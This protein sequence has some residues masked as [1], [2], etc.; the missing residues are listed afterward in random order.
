MC[1]ALC[2]L[3]KALSRPVVWVLS[4]KE[5][6]AQALHS[7]ESIGLKPA[8]LLPCSYTVASKKVKADP[9]HLLLRTEAL[10]ALWQ[11]KAPLILTYP[12]ALLEKA[13]NR[14]IFQA[15]TLHVQTGADLDYT[16]F[17][18]QLEDLGFQREDFVYEPG[19]YA[20]RGGIMD[21][22]S[23]ADT[24]PFRIEWGVRAPLSIR[25]FDPETQRSLR[26]EAG[27]QIVASLGP[28]VQTDT[29]LWDFLPGQT[30]FFLDRQRTLDEGFIYFYESLYPLLDDTEQTRFVSADIAVR[31]YA[32]FDKIYCKEDKIPPQA[33]VFSFNT[34]LQY[35]FN[36]DFKGLVADMQTYAAKGYQIFMASDQ[37]LQ[38]QRVAAIVADI[39]N[40]LLVTPYLAQLTEG[41]VDN[42]LKMVCYAERDIFQRQAAHPVKR[43]FS[44]NQALTLK[45]LSALQPGDFVT[46][47][48]YGVGRFSGLEKIKRADTVQEVIRLIYKNNDVLYVSIHA[49]YKLSKYASA[50]A[51]PPAL[52][53]LGGG[54]WKKLKEKTK[55][56]IKTLAFD[57]ISA[58]A[59]R[60]LEKGYAFSEDNYLQMA[61]EA[62]FIYE[63]TPDQAAAIAAV[64][65]DMES[66]APM[67]RLICGD[68][69][70]GK[71]EI[72][73]RAAF[74]ACMDGKQVAVLAPT[75]VLVF[76]HY[77]TF[78]K[79][80]EE[81]PL[82]I[83]YINRFKT[84]KQKKD[85]IQ[86]LSEG[87]I[88]II[89]GTH[90]LLSKKIRFKDLGLLIVDEEQKF[91][92]EAKE[93]LKTLK[94]NVDCLMLTATPI[95]RTLQF[96]L[97][98]ARD[99]SIIHT[100]PPNRQ[101]VA[102][103]VEDF[104][105]TLIQE[106][107]LREIQRGGQVFFI[108][109]QISDI[110]KQVAMIQ[111]LCPQALVTYAHRRMPAKQLET[112]LLDF[113]A[114]KY[115]VFVSTNI[116]ESGVDIPNT[117]T[118]IIN[119]AQDFGLSDL[120][121]LRGRVG[122]SEKKAYCYLLTPAFHKLSDVS[123]KKLEIIQIFS[124]L[125]AGFKVAMKDLDLR[126]AG[127]ILGGEQSGFMQ[128]VGIDTYQK[129]LLEAV[130]ELKRT[131]FKE[132]FKQ[133]ETL[134]V[135]D[136]Q[137]E[138]DL[139]IFIP[140]DYIE[141]SAERLYF[142]DAV[143]RLKSEAEEAAIRTELTDRFGAIPPEAA[144][145]LEVVALRRLGQRLG[146]EKIVLK[147]G[148]CQLLFVRD[149]GSAFYESPVF[150][151]ILDYVAQATRH[152]PKIQQIKDS[153]SIIFLEVPAVSAAIAVLAGV[154]RPQLRV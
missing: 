153:F 49:L 25:V 36:R 129:L 89:I 146:V 128:E 95:P 88:D 17:I 80:M 106:L 147:N 16:A 61:L 84:L 152:K 69:G 101:P 43:A 70:F 144:V 6:A 26:T 5:T 28:E 110:E 135:S 41:F 75:T 48:D 120:H 93:Y 142:Y 65:R 99:L 54:A 29:A 148:C 143:S 2:A 113:I 21:V 87:R 50:D 102:T 66:A 104:D 119:Q 138:T 111:R 141:N 91:G 85:I 74:K 27:I 117:N 150:G 67:D 30:L 114:H 107:I 82:R 63:E 71:T 13:P 34:V 103:F 37:D 35:P 105:E 64:K 9:Q 131:A 24:L 18:T 112:H 121:Q 44:K 10:R 109:N 51:P 133:E 83:A 55:S 127:N 132:A 140:D 8:F 33:S 126:G 149:S 123:K 92:V 86:A 78:S 76:Q 139:P 81:L 57:L 4:D 15:R 11:R 39:D 20:L 134:F 45:A 1:L 40:T 60:K 77:R 145:L 23:Y 115:D 151:R 122:R 59:Q 98:G 100:P 130:S 72:A 58:Y 154:N 32:A 118:I 7:V 14:S 73:I 79:R 108:H 68:V 96:S 136:C 22:Y 137:L 46:H 47:I 19:Q 52:H 97:M 62:S 38:L 56:S 124:D 94:Y 125:G 90:A 53:Q 42:D 3:K 116:I 31:Y 12:E